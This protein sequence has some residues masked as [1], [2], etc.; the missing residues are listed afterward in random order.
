MKKKTL[1]TYKMCRNKTKQEPSTL[2]QQQ[3]PTQLPPLN[4]F[5]RTKRA[6]RF[7]SSTPVNQQ[8]HSSV[9]PALSISIINSPR[10]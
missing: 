9:S 6:A 4:D 5:R 10:E 1:E 2:Q 8:A 7:L 3:Q